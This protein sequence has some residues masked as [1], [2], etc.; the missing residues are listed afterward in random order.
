MPDKNGCPR[1]FHMYWD[2]LVY[3]TTQRGIF[4]KRSF[5]GWCE[6]TRRDVNPNLQSHSL[7]ARLEKAGRATATHLLL[8]SY[9]YFFC[10]EQGQCISLF[11]KKHKPPSG[12]SLGFLFAN[13]QCTCSINPD[14]VSYHKRSVFCLRLISP[15]TALNPISSGFWE[16]IL[17]RLPPSIMLQS[18]SK[19]KER[20]NEYSHVEIL[21]LKSICLK[22]PSFSSQGPH[23]Y[24]LF[25]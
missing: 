14:L 23:F 2:F 1:I 20:M 25:K 11:R 13:I 17:H 5:E 21:M 12:N 9:S 6:E 15:L 22:R 7:S 19:K 10:F 3:W 8:L 16:T 18:I 4:G 24:C